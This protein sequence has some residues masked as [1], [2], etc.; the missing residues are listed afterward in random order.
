MT[1]KRSWYHRSKESGKCPRCGG[2]ADSTTVCC[3]NCRTKHDEAARTKRRKRTLSGLCIRCG[4]PVAD[5]QNTLCAAHLNVT[6]K[7]TKA[8]NAAI[9]QEV[10]DHYGG[11]CACCGFDEI[12]ALVIDHIDG[13][14]LADKRNKGLRNGSQMHTWLYKH[15]FPDGYQVLCANC[16]TSKYT[17]EKCNLK[18]SGPRQFLRFGPGG[19]MVEAKLGG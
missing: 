2:A 14:G 15:G 5:G 9:R 18:H 6:A 4:Q 3:L 8:R 17:G 11:K 16:N 13:G 1:E 19:K 12:G 7:K 10:I